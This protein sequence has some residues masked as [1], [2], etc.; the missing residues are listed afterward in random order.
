MAA[1]VVKVIFMLTLYYYY[2][3]ILL[4]SANNL[5]LQYDSNYCR[6]PC[7]EDIL[8][9]V[10]TVNGGGATIWEGSIINCPGNGNEIVLSHSAFDNE[11]TKT[12]NDRNI[13]AYD[14]DVTNNIYSSQLNVTVSREM[15]NETVE[16]IHDT[17]KLMQL[18]F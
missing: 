6:H 11:V 5:L 7:P 4:T 15:H 3:T 13:V 1:A 18:L 14:I 12:C 8:V 16:C 9:C 17:L 10:C 2:G